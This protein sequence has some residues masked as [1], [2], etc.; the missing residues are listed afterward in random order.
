MKK[1]TQVK[2]K[3]VHAGKSKT[4][5]KKKPA[6]TA[7]MPWVVVVLLMAVTW[8]L[9]KPS[10]N[11]NFTNWDD[12]DYVLEN[13]H[14]KQF[15]ANAVNFF[16]THPSATNYHPLTMLSLGLDYHLTVKDKKVFRE[17]DELETIRFHTT[18]LLLHLL[19]VLL[20]FVFIYLLSRKRLIVATVTALLFAIHPMH[21]ESVAWI[22]ERKDVLYSFFFLAGLAV[23]MIYLE[24]KSWYWLVATGLLF[25]VSLFSKPSAVVFPLILLAVDYFYGRKLTKGVFLEKIP[26]FILALVFGVVTY[27]VQVHIAVAPAE[28][29]TFFQRVMF[30]SYGFVMYQVKLLLPLKIAAFYPYPLVKAALPVIYYLSPLFSL[31]IVAL[32]YYSKRFTRVFSFGY[33]FYFFCIVLVL[34]FIPVGS[35]IMADRYSYMSSV[36]LFFI[37]AWYLDQALASK[38]KMLRSAGWVLAAGFVLYFIFLGNATM[39]QTKVWQNSE[40]LWTDVISKYPQ[41]KV[42]YKNRGNYYGKL[43]LV[44]KAMDD[45]Q[46]YIRMKTD[47]AGVFSNIGNIYGLRG[48]TDKSLEAYSRSITLDSLESKTWLNRAITYTRAKQF[49]RA[50]KDYEKALAL[51]PGFIPVYENRSYAYREMGRFEDAVGDFNVLISNSP[52]NDEYY[53][54]RGVCFFNL[55]RFSDAQGDFEQCIALNPGNGRAYFN[56]SVISNDAKDYRKAYEYALKAEAHKFSVDKNYL[57]KLKTKGS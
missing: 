49:D 42:A 30:A 48:E 29:F 51:K 20:V 2:K 1:D 15:D 43:N 9:Y 3:T 40:T 37:M 18:S 56:L 33:L 12:P 39:D 41:V 4:A 45:Y 34:Q 14:V 5:V 31:V 23:Y 53:M 54:N 16:F 17:N 57:E 22:A 38:D 35:A 11:N 50:M 6:I 13:T 26:F 36:G 7:W 21:V 10:L 52:R 28:T 8:Y 24:K 46:V 55:K 19:N 47:D 44:D 27:L 25:V 32:V